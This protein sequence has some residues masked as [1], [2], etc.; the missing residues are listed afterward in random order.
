MH[1]LLAHTFYKQPGGED[2]V[3]EAE[4]ALLRQNGHLVTQYREHNRRL[5]NLSPVA[6]AANTVWNRGA[7]ARLN[8]LLERERPDVCHFHNTFPL[9]SPAVFY[10]AKSRGI[11]VVVTLHNYRLLCPAATF[12]RDGKVCDACISSVFPWPALMHACYRASRPASAVTA[13]MLTAH[14]LL[15]T[16]ARKVDVFIALTQFAR[17]KFVEGGLPADKVIVKPN[18]VAADPG[19]SGKR[20][21][22]ALYVGRLSPEKGIATLLAAWRKLE[23]PMKLKLAGDGPLAGEVAAAARQDPRIEWLGSLAPDRVT[24]LMKQARVL[25]FPSIWYEGLPLTVLEAHAAGLPVIASDMGSMVELIEHATSGLRIRPG[26]AEDLARQVAWSWNNR[27]QVAEM[28]RRARAQY[29]ESYTARANYL[30][31]MEVYDRAGRVTAESGSGRSAHSYT[32]G[33]QWL[34]QRSKGRP[35]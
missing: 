10:A 8:H 24:A 20:Q 11:P 17:D 7:H 2:R 25:V 15:R 23:I 16:W 35:L 22:F 13:F 9:M 18:F 14:R 34:W 28:G 27:E 30:Q 12:L 29:E 4:T 5:D 1:I 31:L 32:S 3:F 33:Y 6:A 19:P 26:D 21:D